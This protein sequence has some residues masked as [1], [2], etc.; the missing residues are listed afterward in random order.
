[1]SILKFFGDASCRVTIDGLVDGLRKLGE[2]REVTEAVRR[3]L[4]PILETL[5]R[6]EIINCHC[7][8]TQHKSKFWHQADSQVSGASLRR[9]QGWKDGG[10]RTR[11][12]FRFR[13]R[14]LDMAGLPS[15]CQ[16]RFE[17]GDAGLQVFDN[18]LFSFHPN[19]KVKSSWRKYQY[20]LKRYGYQ[21]IFESFFTGAKIAFPSMMPTRF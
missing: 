9:Q 10:E 4:V 6:W 18:F 5:P 14:C 8:E 3:Y 16:R 2:P 7:E 19:C 13:P 21:Y 20:L 17:K 15:L 12:F 11:R 1:M